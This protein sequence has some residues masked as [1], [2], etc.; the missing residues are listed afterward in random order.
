MKSPVEAFASGEVAE[1]AIEGGMDAGAGGGGAA[2]GV[3]GKDGNEAAGGAGGAGGAAGAE[4]APIVG[5]A[6]VSPGSDEKE[7]MP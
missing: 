2:A 5:I 1:E 7:R 6:L 3:E 4:G